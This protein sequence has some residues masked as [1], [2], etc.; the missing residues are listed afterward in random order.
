M[1]DA[2]PCAD[3]GAPGFV[4]TPSMPV[5]LVLC[6]CCYAARWQAGQE[7]AAKGREQDA[8]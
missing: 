2:H 1:S 6:A 4:V 7:V 3:C 5:P 8:R